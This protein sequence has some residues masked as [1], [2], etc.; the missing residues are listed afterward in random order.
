MGGIWWS[1]AL[2]IVG[3]C[4]AALHILRLRR[5]AQDRAE[6]RQDLAERREE[7]KERREERRERE[8]STARHRIPDPREF[9][10]PGALY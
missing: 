4:V 7:R 5:E 2:V 6:W 3:A 1:I 9:L 10:E 8:R